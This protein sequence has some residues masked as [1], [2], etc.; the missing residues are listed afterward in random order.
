MTSPRDAGRVSIAA[1][2]APIVPVNDTVRHAGNPEDSKE[3]RVRS[4]LDATRAAIERRLRIAND[5]QARSESWERDQ[6]PELTRLAVLSATKTAVAHQ[7][8]IARRL[9]PEPSSAAID[10]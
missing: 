8:Q 2:A 6:E 10:P 3:S 9:G 1:D 5:R 7:E 4:K